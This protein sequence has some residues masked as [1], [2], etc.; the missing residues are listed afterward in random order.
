M[1][2]ELCS[3]NRRLSYDWSL[4]LYPMVESLLKTMVENLQYTALVYILYEHT[5]IYKM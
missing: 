3:L 5:F 2:E 4:G 1:H